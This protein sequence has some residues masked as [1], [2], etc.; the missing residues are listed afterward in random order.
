MSCCKPNPYEEDPHD[1]SDS[2][3]SHDGSCSCNQ[4][5]L[6][7][8]PP[9]ANYTES[10]LSVPFKSHRNLCCDGDTRNVEEDKDKWIP[11]DEINY[12]EKVL[13]EKMRDL[14]LAEIESANR[15][16]EGDSPTATKIW[17]RRSLHQLRT[18]GLAEEPA[19][20]ALKFRELNA[21]LDASIAKQYQGYQGYVQAKASNPSYVDDPNNLV[22]FLR[23]DRYDAQKAAHRMI[24]Y[25]STKLE[26]FG[27]SALTRNIVWEDLG[28]EGQAFLKRGALQILPFRDSKG[29]RIIWHGDVT[30]AEPISPEKLVG[31]V[32]SNSSRHFCCRGERYIP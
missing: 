7:E 4:G 25:Y 18:G 16:V 13:E 10:S 1:L 2:V 15:A 27:P 11:K 29:R 24:R 30:G 19:F 6:D 12:E 26:L 14:S 21:K 9:S 8:S 31:I 32:S 22:G 28:P 17:Q 3:P 20:L 5:C 23:A